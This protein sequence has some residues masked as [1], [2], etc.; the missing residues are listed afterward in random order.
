MLTRNAASELVELL[1]LNDYGIDS[2][3]ILEFMYI[4]SDDRAEISANDKLGLL[5]DYRRLS[6]ADKE[7]IDTCL[8]AFCNP[9]NRKEYGNKTLLRDY[10]NW[11]NESQQIYGLLANSTYFK[12]DGAKL[13]LNTG[14]YGLF[15]AQTK[16]GEKAKAEYFK[17]HRVKRRAGYELHHIV[18]FSKAQNK[19]DAV[20]IDD[21]KNLIYLSDAIH[22]RFTAAGGKNVVMRFM[23]NDP[24]IVFTDFDHSHI[25]VNTEHDALLSQAMLPSMQGYN[26]MLLKKFYYI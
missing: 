12:V 2:I 21:F 16:R 26:G 15:D 7:R 22:Q 13:I 18:P 9:Q 8:K 10:S 3:D 14:N 4:L 24:N 23:P 5:L 17:N 25:V 19:S 20:F 1:Y 6:A 11:K